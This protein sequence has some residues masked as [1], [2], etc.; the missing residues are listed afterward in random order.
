MTVF[1]FNWPIWFFSAT[2]TLSIE[3]NK[4]LSCANTLLLTDSFSTVCVHHPQ[5]VWLCVVEMSPQEQLRYL[6]RNAT[7]KEDA[8]RI[9]KEFM[10][11]QKIKE[12]QKKKE[13]D[14]VTQ[15]DLMMKRLREAHHTVCV[16]PYYILFYVCHLVSVIVAVPPSLCSSSAIWERTSWLMNWQFLKCFNR[17]A[18]KRL[19]VKN[20]HL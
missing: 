9:A 5:L 7:S 11:Q 12:A 13:V 20:M 2:A 10:M 6:L 15:A 14:P 3:S 17:L 19:F 1:H 4:W 16:V 18:T 8:Q